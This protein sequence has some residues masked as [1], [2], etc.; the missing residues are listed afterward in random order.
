MQ[1][2]PNSRCLFVCSETTSY[3]FYPGMEL[4]RRVS[5]VIFRMGGAAALFSNRRD[6][7]AVA[8]HVLRHHV[9]FHTAADDEAYRYCCHGHHG[10]DNAYME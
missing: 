3:A 1:A 10:A 8:K 4:S 5:N 6:D 7:A 9:R 2:R